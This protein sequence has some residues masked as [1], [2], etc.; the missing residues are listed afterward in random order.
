MS[1]KKNRLGKGLD[2]IFGDDVSSVLEDIQKGNSSINVMG[3]MEV[4]VSKVRTNPYQPRKN[5]DQQKIDELAQSIAEHGVFTPILVRESLGGYELIAGERR[6]RATKKAGLEKIPAII[7][8]F[9]DEEMMEISLIEN[10]QREDLNVIEEAMAFFKMIERFNY[11]QEELG[12]RVGKSR[13]YIANILRLLKLPNE[14]QQMVV[15]KKLTMGHVR[16]LITLGSEK[17]MLEVAKK[18]ANLGMSVRAVE[19]ML[20]KPESKPKV[21]PDKKRFSYARR[22]LE[23]K[24]QS[25]VSIDEQRITIKYFGDADLNRILEALGVIEEEA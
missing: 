16:P 7:M 9:T 22:L 11:T 13:E 15:D 10:I 8:T 14:I 18:A 17:E 1:E 4:E 19:S 3:R 12:K 2:A 21:E 23:S 25:K 24:V 6:L 20:K 5:F